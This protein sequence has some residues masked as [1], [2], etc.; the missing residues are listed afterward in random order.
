MTAIDYYLVVFL[1]P[2]LTPHCSS[3]SQRMC[4]GI[5]NEKQ[6]DEFPGL[7]SGANNGCL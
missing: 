4:I 1:C 2:C 6:K 3:L 7:A 5:P